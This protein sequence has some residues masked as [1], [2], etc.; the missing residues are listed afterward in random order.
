LRRQGEQFQRLA[1]HSPWSSWGLRG[2]HAR[3]QGE[4]GGI[5]PY[6]ITS[7]QRRMGAL[8]TSMN[9]ERI[10]TCLQPKRAPSSLQS[11]RYNFTQMKK[12]SSSSRPALASGFISNGSLPDCLNSRGDTILYQKH[13][14]GTSSDPA[15]ALGRGRKRT[16][17]CE[18]F[19]MLLSILSSQ[20]TSRTNL[21]PCALLSLSRSPIQQNPI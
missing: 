18:S 15:A 19:E 21:Q 7:W 16:P 13:P 17:S 20:S 3:E 8:P 9:H 11:T 4:G 6:S 10:S 2:K 1:Q 12:G 5:S 14:L